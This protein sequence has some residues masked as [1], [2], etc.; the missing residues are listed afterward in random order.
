[1]YVPD[2]YR[3]NDPSA[4][5][6]FIRS[7]NFGT[8]ISHGSC[9]RATHIPFVLVD[10]PAPHGSLRC[11]FARANPQ[12]RDLASEAE[13]LVTFVG[14]N[15]YVSPRWFVAAEPL[16]TWAYVAAQVR[17]RP[18]VLHDPRILRE[19]IDE[20]VRQQ[21]ASL[22]GDWSMA[23]Q[24]AKVDRELPGVVAVDIAI[25]SIEGAFTLA[26]H[27]PAR[28]QRALHDRFASSASPAEGALARRMRAVCPIDI[29]DH[30]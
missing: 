6:D 8:L 29:D 24:R 25:S 27:R 12:W 5:R 14:S 11:H 21:E 23:E 30:E 22:G 4:L 7:N 28:D 15:S 19:R 9:L 18:T 10:D 26:Q 17:G 20:L 3:S 13:V 1:M 16:P 2:C